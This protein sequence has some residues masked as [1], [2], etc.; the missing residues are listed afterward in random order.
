[1]Q[2]L[3]I[4]GKLKNIRGKILVHGIQI[5]PTHSS[6]VCNSEIIFTLFDVIQFTCYP[7]VCK[8][9]HYNY[10]ILETQAFVHVCVYTCMCVCD[11]FSELQRDSAIHICVSILPQTP[12]LSRLPYNIE[13]S[14][15]CYIVGPC[16]LSIL[17][18]AVC[19]CL[20]QTPQLSLPHI[21]P[22][23]NHKFVL[24]SL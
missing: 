22:L 12:L 1:M 4:K 7:I 2:C 23:C 21:L 19:T 18:R 17:N 8:F 9:H 24:L 15:M 14:S 5:I 11:S 20:S 6:I 16:W 13:Q 10:L 3:I